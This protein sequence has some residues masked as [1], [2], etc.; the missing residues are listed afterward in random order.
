MY[1][2]VSPQEEVLNTR[3]IKIEGNN[4][5]EIKTNERDIVNIIF[6][7]NSIDTNLDDR[8]IIG[9]LQLVKTDCINSFFEVH[10]YRNIEE[11][12]SVYPNKKIALP[13]GEM[14]FNVYPNNSI[15]KTNE[16]TNEAFVLANNSDVLLFYCKKYFREMVSSFYEKNN[17]VAMHCSGISIDGLANI[18]VAD[19]N[20]GK[21]TTAIN[22]IG[23]G[24][25]LLNDDVIICKKENDKVMVRGLPIVPSIR[26]EGVQYITGIDVESQRKHFSE[27]VQSYYMRDMNLD[28]EWHILNRIIF[29]NKGKIEDNKLKEKLKVQYRLPVE[30]WN[31]HSSIEKL[32]EKLSL[33]RGR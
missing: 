21:S 26:K 1:K 4:V 15:I 8:Q 5:F 2:R 29:L 32:C 28:S 3:Y 20:C 14:I 13:N 11:K 33:D 24:A 22:A 30:D 31:I 19:A 16:D 10:K 7:D 17:C 12:E 23:C 18:F 25:K 6:D 27:Y 9:S